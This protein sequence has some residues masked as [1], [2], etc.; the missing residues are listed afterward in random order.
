MEKGLSQ[1]NILVS[2][3]N[4]VIIKAFFSNE[5]FQCKDVL[6]FLSKF[7]GRM[8]PKNMAKGLIM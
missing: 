3:K 5:Y 1:E 7:A 8:A 2:K 4:C 6:V